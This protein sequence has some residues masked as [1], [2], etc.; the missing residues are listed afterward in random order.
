MEGSLAVGPYLIRPQ[1]VLNPNEQVLQFILLMFP[2]LSI[3]RVAHLTI[4][5]SLRRTHGTILMNTLTGRVSTATLLDYVN[6]GH[7]CR[8]SAWCRVSYNDQRRTYVWWFPDFFHMNDYAHYDIEEIEMQGTAPIISSAS[9]PQQTFSCQRTR[10]DSGTTNYEPDEQ[11]LLQQLGVDDS[12]KHTELGIAEA[13]Y[14]I[15]SMMHL[16]QGDADRSRSDTPDRD[17]ESMRPTSQATSIPDSDD[18]SSALVAYGLN[19]EAILVPVDDDLP[20]DLHKF[21]L[22]K[23]LQL[24]PRTEDWDALSIHYVHPKP[25]DLADCI[26]PAIVLFNHQH[27][28]SD[29]VVLID[30]EMHSNALTVCGRTEDPYTLR[31]TWKIPVVL[32][33]N[34]LLFHLGLSELCRHI[35]LPCLVEIGDRT[36]LQQDFKPYTILNGLY[37]K[38]VVPIPQPEFPLSLYLTYARQ[39]VRFQDMPNHWR[40]QTA[41]ARRR[42]DDLFGSDDDALSRA[43]A[44]SEVTVDQDTRPEPREGSHDNDFSSF[45]TLG[46]VN[47]QGTIPT[48]HSDLVVY[49]W[50]YGPLSSTIDPALTRQ[51]LRETIG[52]LMD[53]QS[54]GST[55]DNFEIHQVRPLPSDLDPLHTTAFVFVHPAT[56]LRD[57]SFA[58]VK[59]SV[60][61]ENGACGRYETATD[62][63]I[64]RVPS[65]LSRQTFLINTQI[66]N[67]CVISGRD[68]CEVWLP[69]RLWEPDDVVNRIV[70]DGAY[71]QVKCTTPFEEIPVQRQLRESTSGMTTA[72]MIQ[73]WQTH[74][75]ATDLSLIQQQVSLRHTAIQPFRSPTMTLRPPGNGK[76]DTL[77]T[78]TQAADGSYAVTSTETSEKRQISLDQLLKIPTPMHQDRVNMIPGPP[79]WESKANVILAT[80]CVSGANLIPSSPVSLLEDRANMIPDPP[81]WESKANVIL[82][83]PLLSGANMIPNSFFPHLEDRA[84]IVPDLYIE[85]GRVNMVPTESH[86]KCK[87]AQD[88][89]FKADGGIL[90]KQNSSTQVQIERTPGMFERILDFEPDLHAP[91]IDWQS[92]KGLLPCVHEGLE[93]MP[94]ESWS[95]WDKEISEVATYTDGSFDG[96]RTWWACVP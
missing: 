3:Q 87:D 2:K 59:I 91:R 13:D 86:V 42:L 54:P 78:V 39:G 36:W 52:A 21:V 61:H 55:W 45:M 66:W 18:P 60:T 47:R 43:A 76:L 35:A 82:A 84:N 96:T 1:P 30:V 83:N 32:T 89:E 70:F 77:D 94:I 73:T 79:C 92:I 49:E 5:T 17:D 68:Q 95:T 75:G 25:T 48:Q 50:H 41:A 11:S 20:P 58:L 44:E 12:P 67:L 8:T 93:P 33:R 57:F 19:I 6:P 7:N 51:Q 90:K 29:A 27:S 88:Q 71:L 63:S 62:R 81:C 15:I 74:P 64:H 34:A 38:V 37:L 14:D 46:P 31:E 40:R 69:D 10:P 16:P 56:I 4:Q 24:E 53:I 23:H 85:T 28:L 80:P 72:T 26:V 65:R 9:P 22:A